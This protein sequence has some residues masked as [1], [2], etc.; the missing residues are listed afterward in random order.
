MNFD[1]Y[2]GDTHHSTRNDAGIISRE[3]SRSRIPG[4]ELRFALTIEKA[5]SWGF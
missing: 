4:S 3:E 1:Y 5:Y 2:P